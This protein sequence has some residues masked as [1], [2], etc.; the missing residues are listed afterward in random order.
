M[1]KIFILFFAHVHNEPLFYANKIHNFKYMSVYVIAV[2]MYN[3]VNSQLP[4]P[5]SLTRIILNP[6][7]DKST[8]I[9][10]DE[11]KV[12]KTIRLFKKRSS[13]LFR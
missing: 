5:P 12:V 8:G 3:C 7:M 10:P 6:N 4:G 13:T 2:Y 11:L 1:Q 9:L